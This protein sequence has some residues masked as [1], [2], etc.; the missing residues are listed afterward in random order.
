[1]CL[2]SQSSNIFGVLDQRVIDVPGADDREPAR[3]QNRGVTAAIE[4]WWS[5][6]SETLLQSLGIARIGSAYDPD[7]PR[8]PALHRLTEKKSPAEQPFESSG[9]QIEPALL[10]KRVRAEVQQIG[11]L[12]LQLP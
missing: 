12:A 7:R 8:A 9:V 3:V 11:R 1:M 5:V 2:G 4:D 10:Q 6:L